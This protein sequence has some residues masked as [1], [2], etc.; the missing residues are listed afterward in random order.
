MTNALLKGRNL[1]T[2]T[3]RRRASCEDEGRDWVMLSHVKG[4]KRLL[5][6]H[7]KLAKRH[8]TDSPSQPSKGTNL[9]DTDLGFLVFRT[10]R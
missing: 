9:S 6:N 3:H 7:Q 10:E 8:G 5:E 4:H 2:D 1:D